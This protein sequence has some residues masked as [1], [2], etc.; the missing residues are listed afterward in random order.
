MPT[1]FTIASTP[2]LALIALSSAF[3]P[4]TMSALSMLLIASS[5]LR[6]TRYHPLF[7]TQVQHPNNLP[8][9]SVINS[10]LSQIITN[11]MQTCC[12]FLLKGEH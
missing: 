4:I 3:P 9:P 6:H 5:H 8:T 12:L 1:N 7:I 2:L 11:S 10:F